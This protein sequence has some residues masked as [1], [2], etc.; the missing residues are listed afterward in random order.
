MNIHTNKPN[1]KKTLTLKDRVAICAILTKH[2][3]PLG[4][5]GKFAYSDGW[6]DERVLK[7]VGKGSLIAVRRIRKQLFGSLGEYQTGRPR[8]RRS[9]GSTVMNRLNKLELQLMELE[10]K[11]DWLET[12]YERVSPPKK[13][14]AGTDIFK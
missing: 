4:E 5:T 7:E 14:L 6:N 11:L 1:M 3:R 12:Y 2:L 13:V 8:A 10:E 9:G